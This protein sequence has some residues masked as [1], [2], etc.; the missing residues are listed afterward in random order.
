MLPPLQRPCLGPPGQPPGG[1]SHARCCWTLLPPPLAFLNSSWEGR[2]AVEG[3]HNPVR[4]IETRRGQCWHWRL[5]P[6]PPL[7]SPR[8]TVQERGLGGVAGE[9]KE[10]TPPQ[11]SLLPPSRAAPPNTFTRPSSRPQQ[12]VRTPWAHTLPPPTCPLLSP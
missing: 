9:E 7:C 2:Q 11:L 5:F 6:G 1:W 12:P 8:T 10:E 3:L 4:G